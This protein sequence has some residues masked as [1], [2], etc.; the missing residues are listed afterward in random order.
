EE[1]K[2]DNFEKGKDLHKKLVA[3]FAK[4][5]ELSD[6]LGSA[7]AAWR[8][9]HPVDTSKFEDGQKLAQSVAD[10][11]RAVLLAAV[12]K[13]VDVAAYKAAVAKAET[14]VNGFK[15]FASSHATDTW[16]KILPPSLDGFIKA[17]KDGEVKVSEKG[18]QSDNFLNLVMSFTSV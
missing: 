3:D 14:S 7:L 4:F 12:S 5:D 9:D 11:A 2:K 6:K 13:K 17:A 10:D 8:K 1:Y 16:G 15:D 18:L